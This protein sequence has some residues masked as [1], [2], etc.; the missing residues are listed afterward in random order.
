MVLRVL[1]LGVMVLGRVTVGEGAAGDDKGDRESSRD[2]ENR[3]L[4]EH[5]PTD[6]AG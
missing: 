6:F 2:G 4:Q 5:L 3:P 1:V